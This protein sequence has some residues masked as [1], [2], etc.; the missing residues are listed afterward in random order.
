M[1]VPKWTHNSFNKKT[2][3][4]GKKEQ[5]ITS[6]KQS[7]KIWIL[8]RITWH[9]ITSLFSLALWPPNAPCPHHTSLQLAQSCSFALSFPLLGVNS[10]IKSS[11]LFPRIF[12]MAWYLG[13]SVSDH[14]AMEAVG[15]I[16]P[17]SLTTKAP[18]KFT[19]PQKEDRRDPTPSLFRAFAVK[20][21]CEVKIIHLSSITYHLP[22]SAHS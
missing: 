21:V 3:Y 15:L 22:Q 9:D 7:P 8:E 11:T 18:A 6:I 14:T 16:L 12:A 13:F 4:H 20:L 2:Y 1:S 19:G 10:A 5:T 17:G